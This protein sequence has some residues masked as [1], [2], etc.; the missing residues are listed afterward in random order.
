VDVWAFLVQNERCEL[1]LLFYLNDPGETDHA[2]APRD[3]P[4]T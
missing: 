2:A 3:A 1:I 4:A